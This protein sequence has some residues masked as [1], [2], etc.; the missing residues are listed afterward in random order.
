MGM[1]IEGSSKTRIIEENMNRCQSAD[2]NVTA[3][4]RTTNTLIE[5]NKII[6]NRDSENLFITSPFELKRIERQASDDFVPDSLS[7]NKLK[8]NMKKIDTLGK[9]SQNKTEND[10][11]N[12]NLSNSSNENGEEDD[13]SIQEGEDQ[14][15]INMDGNNSNGMIM[16]TR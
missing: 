15:I 2:D 4:R 3:R 7:S 5:E 16:S 8:K 6:K 10:K 12:K 9:I 14:S 13:D 11:L 1:G